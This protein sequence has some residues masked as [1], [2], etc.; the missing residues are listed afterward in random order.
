MPDQHHLIVDKQNKRVKLLRYRPEGLDALHA[1]MERIALA[2]R[3]T[4]CIVYAAK[5]DVEKLQSLGYTLEGRIDGFDLGRN[6]YMMA[7]F[8]SE[9]RA[10][11]AAAD[12]A[13]EVLQ[14][15][16]A[17]AKAGAAAASGLPDGYRQR[18]A[19]EADAEELAR[20]Y[21]IVFATYPTPMDDPAY[22][23][24]TMQENTHYTVVECG[25]K[26]VCAASAEV[27]PEY[28]SVEFTDCATHPDHLGRGLLQPLFYTLEAK[29]E[30]IGIYYLYTLT[31]A[32]SHGMNI[33]AAKHGFA[34]RGRLINNCTIYSGFEDMNIWVKPLRPSHD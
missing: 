17:K 8:L 15:S 27:S 4:K 22:V 32:Q 20:L 2:E 12:L 16:L 18:E 33:T 21:G 28:G 30:Q 29:M 24:K 3:L 11:S 9:E 1:E 25:G 14:A 34:Y 19:V 23:R 10:V 5:A 6:A 26:I 7:R 13:E 31:R